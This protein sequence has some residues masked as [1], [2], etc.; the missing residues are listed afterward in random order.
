[1]NS[2]CGL[3]NVLISISGLFFHLL[4]LLN[5]SSIAEN[6]LVTV[7]FFWEGGGDL[8]LSEPDCHFGKSVFKCV[9]SFWG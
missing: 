3:M 7:S 4:M 9:K 8:S 1:M 5:F 6:K 2:L